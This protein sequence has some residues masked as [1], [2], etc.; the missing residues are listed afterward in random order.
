MYFGE[1]DAWNFSARNKLSSLSAAAAPYYPGGDQYDQQ[2]DHYSGE[3]PGAWTHEAHFQEADYN[4]PYDAGFATDAW[5]VEPTGEDY[6]QEVGAYGRNGDDRWLPPTSPAKVLDLSAALDIARADSVPKEQAAHEPW[7]ERF[8]HGAGWPQ[9]GAAPDPRWIAHQS[10]VRPTFAEIMKPGP[11][12]MGDRARSMYMGRDD[13]K[14]GRAA[15]QLRQLLDFY[16]EPFNLQHNRYLV[17]LLARRLGPPPVRGPW[18]SKALEDFTFTFD[19][20]AGLGR[21]TLALHRL[22]VGQPEVLAGLR[23]LCRL[24]NGRLQLQMH[25]EVR[26]FVAAKGTSAEA[27]ENATHYLSAVR[28]HRGKAPTG[29]VS[30]L[31]YALAAA[32]RDPTPR[33]QQRQ[34]QLKRQLL[35]YR[36]DIICLHGLHPKGDGEGIATT[37]ADEGYCGAWAVAEDG[38]ANSIFWDE[39]RLVMI[40]RQEVG[41]ALA[42]DFCSR[43]DPTMII[44]AICFRADV[45][46]ASSQSISQ[47]FCVGRPLIVCADLTQVGGAECSTVSE[48]LARL[49]SLAFEVLGGELQVPVSNSSSVFDLQPVV[50]P[51]S[52][53]NRLHCPDG[54]FYESLTPILTLSGHTDPYMATMPAEDVVRQFPAFRLPIITA[55]DWRSPEAQAAQAAAQG[56]VSQGTKSGKVINKLVQRAGSAK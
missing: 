7:S 29:I 35:L 56:A 37:L 22:R 42:I 36:T 39:A 4:D 30:A 53:L 25:P 33:G 52:R 11:A 48:E 54:M 34:A 32:L 51:A 5:A 20:L 9:T 12:M 28:E 21:I 49:N 38:E 14:S 46:S 55:F 17:D 50:G 47:L 19:D 45:P 24:P 43:E 31:S 13:G 40:Y 44:R 41:A 3:A 16:F 27:V 15:G 1:T 18:L 6:G 10:V 8:G 23:H 26:G 2:L